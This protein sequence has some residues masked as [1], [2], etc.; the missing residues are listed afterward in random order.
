MA[1]AGLTLKGIPE[2]AFG[3][4]L[5][6]RSALDW[7]VDQYRVKTDKRSGITSNPNGYSDDE[8]YIVKLVERVIAVSLKTVDIVES[9]AGLAF[10]ADDE[11]VES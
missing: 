9:L 3:Y 4:R 5:G 11:I 8:Q 2:K 1:T 7:V 6:N 10:R